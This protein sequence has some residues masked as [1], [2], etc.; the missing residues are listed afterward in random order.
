MQLFK[1]TP[2]TCRKLIK[3]INKAMP[4]LATWKFTSLHASSNMQFQI[5]TWKIKSKCLFHM[6][7]TNQLNEKSFHKQSEIPKCSLSCHL[8]CTSVKRWLRFRC[9]V[10]ISLH[11]Q[12]LRFPRIIRWRATKRICDIC[13]DHNNCTAKNVTN[14]FDHIV[15]ANDL[16]YNIFLVLLYMKPWTYFNE[17]YVFAD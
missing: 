4:T 17:D 1:C 16:T 11:N 9:A 8:N 15:C 13:G 14:S 6:P 7:F 3:S 10:L 12:H 5:Y 2:R